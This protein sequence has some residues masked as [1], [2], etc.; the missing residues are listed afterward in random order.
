MSVYN[1]HD[2]IL[3]RL[4]RVKNSGNN[5]WIACC[6]AHDD[7]NPSLCIKDDGGMFLLHCF[8]GCKTDDVLAAIGLTFIDL[9]PET[10][11]PDVALE[12]KSKK[13]STIISDEK[14]ILLVARGSL[15]NGFDLSAADMER[16][17]LANQRIAAAKEQINGI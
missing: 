2:L 12:Y 4:E 15:D 9:F 5:K 14:M 16:I 6:P 11:S 13:L 3:S 1:T 7:R 10:L 17:A 8:A